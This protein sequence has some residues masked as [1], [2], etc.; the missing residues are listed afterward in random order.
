MIGRTYVRLHATA[1]TVNDVPERLLTMYPVCTLEPR[2]TFRG[3]GRLA[4][5]AAAAFTLHHER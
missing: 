4:A 5:A 3:R 2:P 1:K